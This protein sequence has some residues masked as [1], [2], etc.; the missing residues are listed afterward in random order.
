MQSQSTYTTTQIAKELGMTAGMLNKRLRWAG[1]QFRQS[2]QWLLKAPY[3]NQG[4]TATRT[5]VWESRTGE[6]G[7]YHVDGLD[8]KEYGYSYIIFLRLIWYSRNIRPG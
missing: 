2:G 5:H 3:Q 6:T 1:I 4:Y 8:G 7:T